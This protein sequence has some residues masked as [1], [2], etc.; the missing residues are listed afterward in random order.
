MRIDSIS[1]KSFR[2]ASFNP[3]YQPGTDFETSIYV[4]LFHVPFCTYRFHHRQMIDA[5]PRLVTAAGEIDPDRLAWSRERTVQLLCAIQGDSVRLLAD[6][7]T[8]WNLISALPPFTCPQV[9]PLRVGEPPS[10]QR[11][12]RGPRERVH[13][14]ELALVHHRLAHAARLRYSA[15]VSYIP[16]EA[17]RVYTETTCGAHDVESIIAVG[18]RTYGQRRRRRE[19]TIV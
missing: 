13:P 15:E 6:R 5:R 2:G 10:V 9:Q 17:R 14:A 3:G 1:E 8:H 11:A 18:G 7:C 12:V 4:S 19:V 16:K